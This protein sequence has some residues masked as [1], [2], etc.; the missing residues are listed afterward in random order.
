M[1]SV[2]RLLDEALRRLVSQLLYEES[3]SVLRPAD[4]ALAV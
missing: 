1:A 3:S 4:D 2:A